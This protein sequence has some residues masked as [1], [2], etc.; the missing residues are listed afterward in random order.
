MATR[1][2]LFILASLS[3]QRRRFVP[4]MKPPSIDLIQFLIEFPNLVLNLDQKQLFF[5]AVTSSLLERKPN[6]Y[7]VLAIMN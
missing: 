2:W 3:G 6:F 5:L 1:N 7:K 4:S